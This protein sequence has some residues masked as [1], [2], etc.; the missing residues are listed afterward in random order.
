M[1]EALLQW[2]PRIEVLE[3]TVS[4][5]GTGGR[6]PADQ[7]R[8]PGAVHRQPFQPGLPVL[9][10]Q[11]CRLTYRPAPRPEERSSSD[12]CA[13]IRQ[14][15]A[16]DEDLK[17]SPPDP[18]VE[19]SS[20]CLHGIGRSSPVAL[21]AALDKNFLAYLNCLGVS[22]IAPTSAVVP[23]TFTT[24]ERA[25]SGLNIP[26]HTQVAAS[27]PDGGEPV[28]FETVRA[29][30]MTGARVRHIIGLDPTTNTQTDLSRLADTVAQDPVAAMSGTQPSEHL[31]LV[32]DDSVF[33]L[34]HISTLTVGLDLAAAVPSA[35]TRSSLEWFIP[36]PK[37]QTDEPEPQA[38]RLGGP[39]VPITPSVDG[40]AGLQRS[41][42]V[43]FQAPG[44][45][46]E[47]TEIHQRRSRWLG[48]RVIAAHGGNW[49]AYARRIELRAEV[50]RPRATIDAAF[51]DIGDVD[52]SEGL[53]S[54]RPSP[55]VWLDVL[56]RQ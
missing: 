1:R 47:P 11:E 33:S 6:G 34:E 44:P 53:L 8:L 38:N 52:L 3:V 13:E 10:G 7:H 37:E 48:C 39:P 41:G 12:I 49:S 40:T 14:R 5:A 18:S 26:V 56:H 28:V 16:R 15:L 36:G 17:W 31:F 42:E 20:T 30:T 25:P 23:L 50:R 35:G 24:V 27:A 4:A 54:I 9:S 46:P 55:G 21:N 32:G 2:E 43:V 45:W 22:P 51:V 19:A 29:L